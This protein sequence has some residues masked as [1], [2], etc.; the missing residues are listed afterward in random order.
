MRSSFSSVHN[1]Q[2]YSQSH[3]QKYSVRQVESNGKECQLSVYNAG[4]S[5]KEKRGSPVKLGELFPNANMCYQI[6]KATKDANG[7]ILAAR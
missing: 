4:C 7:A 2:P 1:M 6:N 3:T 5:S